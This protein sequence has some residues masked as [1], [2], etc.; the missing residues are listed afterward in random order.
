MKKKE[1]NNN[2]VLKE[3]QINLLEKNVDFDE[4][5]YFNHY[6]SVFGRLDYENPINERAIPYIMSRE[7]CYSYFEVRKNIKSANK[8]TITQIKGRIKQFSGSTDSKFNMIFLDNVKSYSEIIGMEETKNILV[9]VLAKIVEDKI[10]VKIHFLKV[11]DLNFMRY[12][13]AIGDYG[14]CILRQNSW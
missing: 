5:I 2:K 3:N 14:M 10:D 4:N 1:E 11:L 12:L 6:F 7:F 8:E 13:G 9:P